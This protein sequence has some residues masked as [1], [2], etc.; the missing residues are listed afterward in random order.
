MFS[1][2]TSSSFTVRDCRQEGGMGVWEAAGRGSFASTRRAVI[3]PPHPPT[4]QHNTSP[5]LLTA[6]P[7]N[8]CAR[9]QG[10]LG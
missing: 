4:P 8:A 1:I 3:S 6:V 10:R 9:E 2:S 7:L 5:R